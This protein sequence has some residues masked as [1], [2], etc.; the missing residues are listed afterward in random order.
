MGRLFWKFFFFISLSQL[1]AI[2]GVTAS[3]WLAHQGRP[4]IDWGYTASVLVESAS[5]TLKDG[6]VKALHS[7]LQ[8]QRPSMVYA[9][10]EQNTELFGRKV[11]PELLNEI[12]SYFKNESFTRAINETK[13]AD[14]HTYLIFLP[15]LNSRPNDVHFSD[16]HHSDEFHIP[17]EPIFAAMFASLIFAALL[18][19][20]FSKP[21]RNLRS[22]FEAA[23]TGNLDVRLGDVMGQRHDELADLGQTASSHWVNEAT[24]G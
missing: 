9:V 2:L 12:R 17:V 3:F 18:A 14:G 11:Q 5:A 10:D 1:A 13:T 6:G 23:T 20:Y 24:T 16:G 7:V 4:N 15:F 19:R 22:A 8:S 21:I